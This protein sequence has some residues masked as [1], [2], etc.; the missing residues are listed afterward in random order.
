PEGLRRGKVPA[1]ARNTMISCE[2]ACSKAFPM[3]ALGSKKAQPAEMTFG[4]PPQPTDSRS[5]FSSQ[6]TYRSV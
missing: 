6:D 2:E 3:V 1:S 5:F 4:G